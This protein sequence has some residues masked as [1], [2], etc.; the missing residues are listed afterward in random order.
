MVEYVGQL[1]LEMA[2]M[3]AGA[4]EDALGDEMRLLAKKIEVRAI[5]LRINARQAEDQART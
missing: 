2:D 5:E 3:C 1:A 4:G